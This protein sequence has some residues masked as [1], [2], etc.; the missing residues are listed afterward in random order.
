VREFGGRLISSQN[1]T[2]LLPV[3]S[4]SQDDEEHERQ[5]YQHRALTLTLDSLYAVPDLV[6]AALTPSQ[7]YIPAAVDLGTGTGQWA[8]EFAREFPHAS[9]VGI[10]L[11]PPAPKEPVPPNCRFEVDDVNLPLGHYAKA[12]NVCHIRGIDHGITN[13]ENFLYRV[14]QILRTNGVLLLVGG[15]HQLYMENRSPFPTDSQEGRQGWCATQALFWAVQ[16]TTNTTGGSQSANYKYVDWLLANPYF[17]S[18][19]FE[20]VYI[21]IGPWMKGL[22]NRCTYIA[23]LMQANTI[24]ILRSFKPLLLAN[25][26]E[27]T[28]LDR[29]ISAG[30]TELTEMKPRV[31]GRWRWVWAIRNTTKWVEE[32]PP[33][34]KS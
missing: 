2:Y 34:V 14:A 19:G 25:G 30:E 31:F 10:D 27:S 16:N 11:V 22:D 33:G 8:I 4:S 18:V 26:Y 21:P 5:E 20:D 6:K 9:V 29:W 23:Q 32:P 3:A 28:L 7:K 12:F 13:F 15:D 24:R 1:E 17:T